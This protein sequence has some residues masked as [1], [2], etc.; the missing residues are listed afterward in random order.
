MPQTPAEATDI[1]VVRRVLAGDVNA[2]EILVVR[3]QAYVFSIVRKHVPAQN[4]EAVAHDVFVR[5]YRSLPKY[6]QKGEFSKWLAGISVRTCAGFWRTRYR[7]REVA[8]SKLSD[9][10]RQWMENMIAVESVEDFEAGETRQAAIQVLDWALSRMS[11]S[12]R[13]IIELVHLEGHSVKEAA[14]L[15]GCS[16]ANVKIRAF[17]ARKKLK[18]LVDY[19]EW[20]RP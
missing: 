8:V 5:A 2:F 13:M 4:L 11:D 17:R 18:K 10:H 20:E 9:N 6:Q 12:E 7:R 19:Q 1:D 14:V 3:Y 16:V 15:M